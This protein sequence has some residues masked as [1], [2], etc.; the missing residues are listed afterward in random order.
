VKGRAGVDHF[1]VREVARVY[2]LGEKLEGTGN[3]CLRG[4]NRGEDGED[5]RGVEHVR[6]DAIE[7]GVR[8]G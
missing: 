4:D 6:R 1:N 8:V 3:E 7:K 2:D 5:E